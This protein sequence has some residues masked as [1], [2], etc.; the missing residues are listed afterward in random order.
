MAFVSFDSAQTILI[1]TN[2]FADDGTGSNE[3]NLVDGNTG[4]TAAGEIRA[5]MACYKAIIDLGFPV[6]NLDN[7]N[8]S[9]RIFDGVVMTVGGLCVM[10]PYI[11]GNSVHASV[12]QIT[13]INDNAAY[14]EFLM[15]SSWVDA[16]ADVGTDQ[17]AV[18]FFASGAA[19]GRLNEL[20]IEFSEV[21]S[22]PL[23][24]TGNPLT[25]E[26]TAS[27]IATIVKP[28]NGTPSIAEITAN[29]VSKIIKP[30]TGT[31]STEVITATGVANLAPRV[32]LNT[33]QTLSG[34]T[35]MT[36]TAYNLAG[37]SITF[38]DPAGAPTGALFLGVE[39]V[40]LGGGDSNTGWIAV[41]V[42]AVELTSTGTPSIAEITASGISTIIKKATGAVVI[43][44]V[45]ASGVS[46][47]SGDL[48]TSDGTPSIEEIT[49]SG[50]STIIKKSD[51]ALSLDEIIAVGQSTQ[52]LK[53][54]GSPSLLEIEAVG[55]SRIIKKGSGSLSLEEIGAI[56][57]STQTLKPSGTPS[58]EEIAA[59]GRSGFLRTGSGAVTLPEIT[60]SGVSTL[61]GELTAVGNPS[62]A[63]IIAAGNVI[64]QQ[65]LSGILSIDTILAV[66]VARIIKRAN[67]TITLAEIIASGIAN[68]AHDSSGTPSINE[69]L[70]AGI[71]NI[72][73]KSS[74][75]LSL[76]E[77]LASGVVDQIQK[78]SGSPSI[79]VVSALGVSRI[80]KRAS[81]TPAI[82]SPTALGVASTALAPKVWLNTTQVLSGATE[83]TVT[84]FN[85]AGTSITFSDPSGAP[86]GSL[87][88]GVENRNAGGGDSNTGWIAVTVNTPG[89]LTSDGMPS[90]DV[91]TAN[92]LSNL[93]GGT[94]GFPS[95]A[96]I[97][98][99]GVSVR[100]PPTS[101]G[102][103]SIEKITAAGISIQIQKLSGALS[104]EEITASGT[105]ALNVP[106][107]IPSNGTP[108]IVEIEALGVST[109]LVDPV[110]IRTPTTSYSGKIDLDLAR[111][112]DIEDPATDRAI[113]FLHDAVEQLSL[114]IVDEIASIVK[115]YGGIKQTG[116]P[117]ISNLGSGFQV[118]PADAGLITTPIEVT[119]DFINDGIIVEKSGV[120]SVNIII[121]LSHN[122]DIAVRTIEIQ[123]YND[124]DAA[125]IN[126]I[127]IPIARN[128]LRTFISLAIMVEI[129]ESAKNDL[130]QIRIGNG[131]T[132]TSVILQAYQFSANYISEFNG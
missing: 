13:A 45:I 14:D 110:D 39:N 122:E 18:R 27:G 61:Q 25:A 2:G 80:I 33:S 119:Q 100:T 10:H 52:T 59:S 29:G 106:P 121:S 116:T 12:S 117:G 40:N 41:T 88:L 87:F 126:A 23:T 4:T 8:L 73:K 109:I 78:L 72:L 69:I 37:T 49:A 125:E 51:G 84:A 114:S 128:Q 120:W 32:Y 46:I 113:A 130:L 60:V 93:F 67:G 89:L 68:F 50:I 22:G 47:F 21:A 98:A 83:M 7:S 131:S 85:G 77:I 9:I 92:G 104:I 108:S 76:E 74:G 28:A 103:P 86:T 62:I 82:D 31:P 90:I 111:P 127:R 56:G 44:A 3:A 24:A 70:A 54:S 15:D 79:E 17:I 43:A 16:L 42:N 112:G 57:T 115:G 20:Q 96:E 34:A 81:G 63:E 105:V 65:F 97:T 35:E 19:R 66:G 94:E 1:G 75:A 30:S 53:P 91:I 123:L 95:I 132:V 107:I 6:D 71:S 5:G 99:S 129:P 102:N 101:T 48:L 26:V 58:I 118:V 36:V 55:I 124:N 11:D 64:Q 38:S